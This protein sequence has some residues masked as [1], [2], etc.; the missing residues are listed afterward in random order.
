MS[1]KD[2]SHFN[3]EVVPLYERVLNICEKEGIMLTNEMEEYFFEA[4]H[5]VYQM[6][7]AYQS[8]KMREIF[9]ESTSVP[10]DHYS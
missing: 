1:N 2:D 6:G 3:E 5:C 8:K 10:I 9:K 7:R 4:M